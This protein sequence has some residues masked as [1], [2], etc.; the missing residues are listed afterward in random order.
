MTNKQQVEAKV[1][2]LEELKLPVKAEMG[3]LTGTQWT[4][5]Y[6]TSDGEQPLVTSKVV[7]THAHCWGMRT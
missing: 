5:V 2:Q 6:T 4:T 1:K 3:L 7:G